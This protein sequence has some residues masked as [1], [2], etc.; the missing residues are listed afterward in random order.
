M[1][2]VN[3][4]TGSNKEE[5]AFLKNEI[6]SN[7]DED[8]TPLLVEQN[9]TLSI[10]IP[11]YN[12]EAQ[13]LMMTINSL[14]E[15]FSFVE[16]LGY[17]PH[18]LLIMDGWGKSSESMKKKMMEFFPND[19]QK[20]ACPWWDMI[21]PKNDLSDAV[22]TFI[23]Q[24]VSADDQE[25]V[26]V[27]IGGNRRVKISCVIKRDNRRKV[28]SH[29][30]MLSSFAD[31]YDSEFVFLT[32]CGTLFDKFCLV[33]LLEE[34]I[35]QDTCT[36]V[37]GRQRVMTRSQQGSEE[38][39]FGLKSMYRAA[40]CYDYENSLAAFVGAFS[41][42]GMLPVIPGPCGL[43]R[44]SAI[45]DEAVPFYLKSALAHPSECG[46]L[47]SNLNLAEDRI[48]SY[49]AVLKS[50]EK[51]YTCYVPEAV[52]YFAAETDPHQFFQQRRRW[53]NG[54]MAGYIWLF[55]NQGIVWNS[56]I[57]PFSKP[58]IMMLVLCQTL[59]YVALAIAPTVFCISLFWSIEWIKSNFGG[60]SLYPVGVDMGILGV[61]ILI[62]IAFAIRHSNPNNKTPVS[63]FLVH[64]STFANSIGIC[65]ILYAMIE[66]F[67]LSWK[68]LGA[69]EFILFLVFLL[70][71]FGPQIL[72]L[73]HSPTSFGLMLITLIPYYM[74][75]PTMVIYVGVYSF[76]RIWD[77]SWGNRPSEK[78]SLKSKLSAKQIQQNERNVQWN[79]RSIAYS[80]LAFN[81]II[82]TLYMVFY[83]Q[84]KLDYLIII[85]AV[86]FCFQLIQ[87][88]FSV[89]YFANRFIN[90]L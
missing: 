34:L 73:I 53:T 45:K 76:S 14:Y 29:D 2:G 89:L 66:R 44:Y 25:I 48:L 27:D 36:G 24:Y 35:R 75:L 40:Q 8:I 6:S 78:Y 9:K 23:L 62:Y 68:S 56:R 67:L 3:Y 81:L 71:V 51:A 30:W 33:R 15:G 65:A 60:E 5:T 49:A 32:D 86:L 80:V 79:G 21:A 11:F 52:F 19:D 1:A 87:M 37:S 64:L 31:F 47:L 38:F 57:N 26:P 22:S 70:R 55:F 90:R 82:L 17:V 10:L 88:A 16:K 28:N 83:Q 63:N 54:T 18:I 72:A 85:I 7:A 77:I 13:E 42:F 69:L 46:L 59:M 61:Y 43:Y 20:N 4:W 84:I 41:L 74:F 39:L 58:F 50:H 12:E